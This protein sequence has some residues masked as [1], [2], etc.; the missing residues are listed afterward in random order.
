[1]S[2]EPFPDWLV[3][4]VGGW[5]AEDLDRLPELP[6]HTELIDGNLV[7]VSPQTIFHIWVM[8]LL[9]NGLLAAVP[10]S[11]EV[12]REIT[13]VLGPKN[14]PE[15]DLVVV[16][17]EARTSPTQTSFRAEDV[18]LAVEVVSA[19]S[20]ERDRYVKH[21]KYAAAGIPFYWRIE[22]M[23]GKPVVYAY[24]L[25]PATEAYGAATIMRD[26]LDLP[27]P[28]PVRIELSSP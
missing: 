17:A 15:P 3:P 5:T 8:R 19:E 1:M 13:V 9:E 23:A 28:F 18:L 6:P 14:R 26:V 22:S 7:F 16:K 21:N 25:D 27:V 10:K 20:E 11:W 4:P 2:V 12:W 24:E